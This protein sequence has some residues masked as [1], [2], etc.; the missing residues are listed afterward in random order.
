MAVALTRAGAG[1]GGPVGQGGRPVG[2]ADGGGRRGRPTGEAN[3][4]LFERYSA[5]GEACAS[6]HMPVFAN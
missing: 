4:Y 5:T 2:Q 3:S 1:T 6:A